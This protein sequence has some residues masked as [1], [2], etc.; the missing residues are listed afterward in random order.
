MKQ[1]ENLNLKII[2]GTDIPSFA[3]FNENMN[4]LDAFA[5]TTSDSNE[6]QN[7]RI[8]SIETD[9]ETLK[10]HDETNTESIADLT[11][12]VKILTKAV[13]EI[14][15]TEGSTTKKGKLHIVKFLVEP[16]TM[17]NNN[18]LF[19]EFGVDSE[20]ETRISAGVYNVRSQINAT[21]IFGIN[22]V[23]KIDILSCTS[24]AKGYYNYAGETNPIPMSVRTLATLPS[25]IGGNSDIILE[26]YGSSTSMSKQTYHDVTSGGWQPSGGGAVYP[27]KGSVTIIL[28]AVIYE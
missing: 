26:L 11:D 10:T 14:E 9:V 20:T 1:T 17:T 4:K 12:K 23:S 16:S 3:P 21:E 24:L 28:Q 2:E 27:Q 18:Y 19:Q 15:V 25:V 22:D 5:K 8:E 6:N 13:S 7:L